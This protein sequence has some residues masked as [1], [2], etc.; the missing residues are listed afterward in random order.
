MP[1]LIRQAAAAR[2]L[3]DW[4][5][6]AKPISGSS[7]TRGLLLH[8]GED[9]F[10]EA[11]L[12]E[13][14]PGLWECRVTRDEFCHFLAGRCVYTRETGE[15]IEISAGDTAFFPA[16]WSGVCEVVATVRKV[17]LIR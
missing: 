7:R 3:V 13:C 5:P 11:G 16:G 17:Y 6:I 9:G 8:R 4:G 12:W 1:K 14:T 15:R 10:P 2:E